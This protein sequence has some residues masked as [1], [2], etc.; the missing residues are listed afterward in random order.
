[1][2]PNAAMP[3]LCSLDESVIVLVILLPGGL[4]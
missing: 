1:M 3:L 4:L 2:L